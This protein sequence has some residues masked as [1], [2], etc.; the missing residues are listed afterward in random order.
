MVT[1]FLSRKSEKLA[2]MIHGTRSGF[3]IIRTLCTTL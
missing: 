2:S 1:G 3:A